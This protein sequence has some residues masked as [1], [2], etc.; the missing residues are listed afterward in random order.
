MKTFVELH[1]LWRR[2]DSEEQFGLTDLFS[3]SVPFLRRG[4]LPQQWHAFLLRGLAQVI[5]ER[6]QWQ[7]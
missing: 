7:R 4:L 5:V 2:Q 1:R 6:G 3:R